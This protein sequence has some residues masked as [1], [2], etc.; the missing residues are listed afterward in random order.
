MRVAG[1][2]AVPPRGLRRQALD[3]EGFRALQP[4]LRHP[5]PGRSARRVASKLGHLLAVGGMS[6]EFLGWV[7]GA[8]SSWVSSL[9]QE[10]GSAK[11]I[12]SAN[13]WDRAGQARTDGAVV[14]G[15]VGQSQP[16]QR[17]L[18]PRHP[19]VHVG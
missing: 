15:M 11:G 19:V 17:K 4:S 2:L 3:L 6:Q 10:L 18:T 16:A 8:L 14:L 13:G 7:H 5:D 12:S 1:A 9:S